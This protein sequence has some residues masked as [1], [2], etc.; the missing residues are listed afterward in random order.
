MKRIA[1]E[2]EA[3]VVR[4]IEYGEADLIAGLLTEEHGRISAFAPSARKSHK[5]FGAALDLFSLVRAELSWP[6]AHSGGLWRLKSVDLL[7]LHHGIR[8]DLE[9]F[10]SA[11][12]F[13]ECLWSLAGEG[14]PQPRLFQWWKRT[15]KRLSE[16]PE[17]FIP[18]PELDLE[19]LALLGHGPRWDTCT[20]C[21]L[22]PTGESLFF[23][24]ERGGVTCGPCRKPGEGRWLP[25]AAVETLRQGG[26]LSRG[27]RNDARR[28]LD[29]FVSYT[30]GREPRSQRFREEVFSGFGP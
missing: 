20:E 17:S 2:M 9:R 6:A 3:I 8:R 18:G 19:L 23:S 5:R 29:D 11:A 16:S 15:L 27:H 28:A 24:F 30:L 22:V 7:D 10:A 4:L 12:Y 21:G 1:A 14:D 13:S 25:R 26:D